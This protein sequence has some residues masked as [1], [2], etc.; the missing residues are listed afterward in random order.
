MYGYG[1]APAR[2]IRGL[3]FFREIL[4]QCVRSRPRS[5]TIVR[6]LARPR[7]GPA[8]C[9]TS[10]RASRGGSL[11]I[12]PIPTSP[13]ST[14]IPINPNPDDPEAAPNPNNSSKNPMVPASIPPHGARQWDLVGLY[15]ISHYILWVMFDNF[16]IWCRHSPSETQLNGGT[17]PVFRLISSLVAAVTSC[18]TT[19]CLLISSP[20]AFKR[21]S[22]ALIA[23]L[24]LPA[25][26]ASSLIC[27]QIADRFV[28]Q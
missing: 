10:S 12:A 3:P 5:R 2:R 4:I 13:M 20:A 27:F 6:V 11:M 17:P 19:C 7:K 28:Q 9:C 15:A 22:S 23:S 16:C 18:F 24:S 14:P 26:H 1:A 21:S 25:C 8:T